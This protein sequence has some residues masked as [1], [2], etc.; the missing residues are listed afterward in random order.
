MADNEVARAARK[1]AMD[2]IA[3]NNKD[4]GKLIEEKAT[5][6]NQMLDSDIGEMSLQMLSYHYSLIDDEICVLRNENRKL[7]ALMAAAK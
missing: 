3:G 7:I 6:V 1:E 5:Y 4:I 2:L